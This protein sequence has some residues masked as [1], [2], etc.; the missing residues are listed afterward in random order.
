MIDLGVLQFASAWALPL[1][2]GFL[3]GGCGAGVAK[4]GDHLLLVPP[5]RKDPAPAAA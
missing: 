3:Y 4:S 5:P 1:L 2:L